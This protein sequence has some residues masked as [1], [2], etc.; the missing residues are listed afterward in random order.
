L[1]YASVRSGYQGR[2][3]FELK[4][5]PISENI[6]FESSTNRLLFTPATTMAATPV[7][8]NATSGWFSSSATLTAKLNDTTLANLEIRSYDIRTVNILGYL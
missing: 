1:P 7:I 6:G 2:T 3:Q 8:F 4:P 5:T